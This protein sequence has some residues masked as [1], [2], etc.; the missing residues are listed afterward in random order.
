MAALAMA[1]LIAL[2]AGSAA[3]ADVPAQAGK[4]DH[5]AVCFAGLSYVNTV[6][7]RRGDKLK[8][9]QRQ[10]MALFRYAIPF[11]AARLTA[12]FDDDQLAAQMAAGQAAFA[13]IHDKGAATVACYG[14]YKDAMKRVTAALEAAPAPEADAKQDE[15]AATDDKAAAPASDEPSEEQAVSEGESN[16]AADAPSDDETGER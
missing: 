11:Y 6:F 7:A 10:Q 15:D 13:A 16:A 9:A 1:G 2:P 4:V 12:S 5:D 14:I 3:R 8:P